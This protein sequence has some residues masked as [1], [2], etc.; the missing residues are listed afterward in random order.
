MGK[1]D[2][3]TAKI[4]ISHSSKD[5]EFVRN[6]AEDLNALGHTP[7]LDEHSIRVGDCIVSKVEEGVTA[8][9]YVVVALS[10]NSVN[11]GWVEREWKTKYWDEVS[12][13]R[14]YVL[15]V[16]LA[17]CEIPIFLKTKKYA[18]FRKNYAVGLAQLST[19]IDPLIR[20]GAPSEP[21]QTTD[22]R[23]ADL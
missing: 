11:S 13:R 17:D 4:F 5:K 10:P 20:T 2:H 22:T 23:T 1:W 16:L 6:L 14:T 9:D 3:L 21:P 12:A 19:A 8:A 15:P 7:W 18:D